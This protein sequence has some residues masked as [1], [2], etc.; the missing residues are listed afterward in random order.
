MDDAVKCLLRYKADIDAQNTSGWLHWLA[1]PC[2]LCHNVVQ[3]ITDKETSGS[4]AKKK[5][6]A[7]VLLEARVAVDVHDNNERRPLHLALE[8]VAKHFIEF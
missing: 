2:T 7:A 8:A 1:V 3:P 4:Y 6:T 5:A